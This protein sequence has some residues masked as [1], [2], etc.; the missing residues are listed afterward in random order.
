MDKTLILR[1]YA[2]LETTKFGL[3]IS[4]LVRK[5]SRNGSKNFRT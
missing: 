3:Y 4:S 2:F 5:H 1:F